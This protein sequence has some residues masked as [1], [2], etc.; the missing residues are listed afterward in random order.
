[1]FSQSNFQ[2][3]ELILLFA[4]HKAKPQ[5]W[6]CNEK[7]LST[8]MNSDHI[9][10]PEVYVSALKGYIQTPPRKVMTFSF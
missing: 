2:T 8:K 7:I 10:A 6:K 4:F 9:I 3:S 5:P 1:M